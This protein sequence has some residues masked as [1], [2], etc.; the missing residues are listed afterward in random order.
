MTL[1]TRHICNL[2]F[3]SCSIVKNL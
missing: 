3:Q 1:L 2:S